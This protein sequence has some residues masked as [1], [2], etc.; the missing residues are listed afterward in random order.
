MGKARRA[1]EHSSIDWLAS[2]LDGFVD[3]GST[4]EIKELIRQILQRPRPTAATLWDAVRA[5]GTMN[6]PRRWRSDLEA[7]FARMTKREQRCAREAM[8]NYY[9]TIWEP[10]LALPFCALR[11]LRTPSELM[12]AMDV[13]LHLN[14]LSDAK[15]VERKC[16]N[17]IRQAEDPFN[18]SLIAEALASFYARTRNWQRALEIWTRAPRDQ[19]L[20]RNAA[21]GRAEV[22]IAGAI[23]ALN[24]ELIT[25]AAL[26]KNPP[27]ELTLKLPGIE[28]KL[29]R[30]TEGD[31]L[32]LKRGLERAFGLNDRL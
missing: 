9:Y 18:V 28:D 21:V 1:P 23:D 4:K 8:L 26:K 30:D 20:A 11:N 7:A 25:V 16:L 22:F 2:E 3:L 17:A 10:E 31:L 29:L 32:R 13:Y 24:E 12:F 14:K 19:P 6:S 5:I 15:K 27:S